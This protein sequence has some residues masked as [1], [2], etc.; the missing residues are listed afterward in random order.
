MPNAITPLGAA[1]G[2]P[3]GV[4]AAGADRI[5]SICASACFSG[6][7]DSTQPIPATARHPLSTTQQACP[8][9]DYNDARCADRFRLGRLAELFEVCCGGFHGCV[10]YHRLNNETALSESPIKK[11]SP[12]PIELTIHGSSDQLRATGS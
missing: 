12:T 10:L 11:G 3:D 2:S 4:G 6:S 8:Y 5:G 9:L 7:R 1:G